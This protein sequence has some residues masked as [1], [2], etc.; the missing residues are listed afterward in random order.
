MHASLLQLPQAVPRPRTLAPAGSCKWTDPPHSRLFLLLE[1]HVLCETCLVQQTYRNPFSRPDRCA[2]V[3]VLPLKPCRSRGI[4]V[5]LDDPVIQP[6][7]AYHWLGD[8]HQVVSQWCLINYW[9]R[10]PGHF[11]EISTHLGRKRSRTGYK[12]I[13]ETSAFESKRQE[14]QQFKTVLSYR[15]GLWAMWDLVSEYETK[16]NR[17]RNRDWILLPT[18]CLASSSLTS[19]MQGASQYEKDD[20]APPKLPFM[21]GDEHTLSQCGPS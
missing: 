21:S 14:D 18:G 15:K 12:Q 7:L 20:I 2:C 13:L 16:T 4:D 10:C 19:Q 1:H 5:W 17:E 11:P 9:F 6:Q 8:D 3:T